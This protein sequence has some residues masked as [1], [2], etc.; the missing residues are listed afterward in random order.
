MRWVGGQ[1]PNGLWRAPHP[2][3]AATAAKPLV[4]T[5][6]DKLAI[7]APTGTTGHANNPTYTNNLTH[8]RADRPFYA[9]PD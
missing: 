4:D 8:T 9:I 1:L 7:P 3:R 6:P 2:T 5:I